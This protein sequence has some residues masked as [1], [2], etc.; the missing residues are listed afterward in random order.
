MTKIIASVLHA[1]VQY[2]EQRGEGPN[3]RRKQLTKA[4]IMAG[5]IVVAEKTLWGHYSQQQV[6]REFNRQ[7]KGW[8]VLDAA[9]AK[10]PIAA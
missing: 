6:L 10:L 9:A 8:T 1:Q 2:T 4:R 5:P 7:P 3:G